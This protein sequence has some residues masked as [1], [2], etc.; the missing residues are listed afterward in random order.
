[1]FTKYR[2]EN[3]WQTLHTRGNQLLNAREEPVRLMGVNCG[4][5]CWMSDC[6]YLLD[7]VV[8][9]CDSWKANTIRL[10]LAQDSWFGFG[11]GQRDTDESGARYRALVDEVVEAVASRQ[12]YVILDLHR[13]NCNTW[14]PFISGGLPD[15]NSLVFW[16][17]VA[18]RYQN[19]PNVLFDLHNEP[20][21][22]TWDQW[23]NGGEITVLYADTD[24]G[25]Q[26]MFEK[27][28]RAD[29]KTLTYRVPGMQ[30][31]VRTVRAV[32]ARNV[33]TIGGLDWSYELDG[34]VRGYGLDDCGGNGI[35]LDAHVYPCKAL[36]KWDDYV[37]VAKDAYPI[38]IGEF[39]HYGEA[40]VPHE[41]P[42]LEES[43]TWVPKLL[44][45]IDRHNYHLT[46]W[47]FHDTAG[48]CLVENLQDYTPTP[49]WGKYVY[50]FLAQHAR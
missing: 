14:G 13:T 39:G 18:G 22:V 32:G 49:Y 6:D 15:M 41:W 50:D 9:A 29:L 45:W 40:P 36:D 31:M 43:S 35:I 42:Q 27:D 24:V 17:S 20:F 11:P 12:K 48:P 26:I 46:A 34:I 16:K 44:R 21:Q 19:H 30:E 47:D 4:P 10:P 1:M 8:T 33:L 5:L 7:T 23:K 2:K 38:L 3:A 28:D 37:T 25:Q